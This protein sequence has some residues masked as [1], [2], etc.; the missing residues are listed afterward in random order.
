V[1]DPTQRYEAIKKAADE[2]YARIRGPVEDVAPSH[3]IGATQMS[4]EESLREYVGAKD[5]QNALDLMLKQLV[6]DYGFA[7]GLKAWQR[8]VI[9]NEA[10]LG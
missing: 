3:P 8:W 4:K 2:E 9:D 6:S 7:A 10:Q 5:D 1:P